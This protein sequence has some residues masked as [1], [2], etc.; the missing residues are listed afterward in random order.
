MKTV[1]DAIL[2]ERPSQRALYPE[3]A[4]QPA[5]SP[6][7]HFH[8]LAIAGEDD[9]ER[10]PYKPDGLTVRYEDGEPAGYLG[11]PDDAQRAVE[12]ARAEAALLAERERA[13]RAEL[14][15]LRRS[16]ASRLEAAEW[17]GMAI[18]CVVC[19]LGAW[20]GWGLYMLGLFG[21]GG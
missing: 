15:A 17:R 21:G 20:L 11:W 5:P 4:P 14:R 13:T 6:E 12:V 3:P 10:L 19:A 18:G 2:Y 8:L 16:L 1:N 7:T 9:S